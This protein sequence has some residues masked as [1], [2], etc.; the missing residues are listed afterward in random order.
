MRFR[1]I[2]TAILLLG[3]VATGSSAGQ[4]ATGS[5]VGRASDATKAAIPGVNLEI[6]NEQTAAET[7]SSDRG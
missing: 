2:T 5:I 7:D 3:L 1:A 6:T 4:T